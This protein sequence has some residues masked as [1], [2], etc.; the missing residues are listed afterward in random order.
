MNIKAAT[1]RGI[2]VVFTPGAGAR[3]V[4]EGAMAMILALVKKLPEL[5]RK[6][7]AGEWE[8]RDHTVIGDLQGAVL[9][10]IGLGRIGRDVAR[11]AHAFDMRV[12]SYDPEVPKQLAE[13]AGAEP[14]ELDSL[15]KE[16]DVITLHALLNEQTR[17][18]LNRDRLGL[19]KRGAVLVNLARGGLMES[20]DVIYEALNSGQ[21]SAVGLDVYAV[22]PPN[23]SHPIFLHPN[24]LCSPHAMGLSAKAAQSIFAMVSRGM[25]EVLDGGA[26]D[27]V[28]NPEVFRTSSKAP[29]AARG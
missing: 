25:A 20:L 5:D 3:A 28:V 10:I 11:L 8:A 15:L 7:R 26:P 22:E 13:E 23:V 18:I 2:P 14:V 1:E 6:T 17:G 16:S 4:A 24:V 12:I 9:G 19:V 29:G 21:L 27:N